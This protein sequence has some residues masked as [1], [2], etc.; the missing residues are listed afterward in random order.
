M[1]LYVFNGHAVQLLLPELRS[2]VKPRPQRHWPRA[3]APVAW[4]KLL[5]GHWVHAALPLLTL[6]VLAAHTAGGPRLHGDKEGEK[7]SRNVSS[8]SPHTPPHAPACA[9]VAVTYGNSRNCRYR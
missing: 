7:T 9:H 1:S 8:W 6:Y 4:V 2:P 5:A 3:I